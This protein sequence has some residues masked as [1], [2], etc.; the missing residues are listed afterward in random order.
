[1]ASKTN[2]NNKKTSVKQSPLKKII[3]PI[4]S[5]NFKPD[6]IEFSNVIVNTELGNKWINT[7]INNDKI[8]LVARGCVVK[9][10]KKLDNND[11]DSKPN[12]KKDSSYAKKDK[13]QAFLG[14]TDADFIKA[15]KTYD[16][17]LISFGVKRSQELFDTEMNADECGE[18]FKSTLSFHDKY[19][20]AI[21]GILS[22][23]FSCESKTEDVPDVS[24]LIAALDKNTV[25]DV[26]FW[27]N[28]IKLG[29]G[30]YSVGLE[31]LKINITGLGSASQYKSN[32]ITVDEFQ[33]G[34]ITLT[35][36]EVLDKGSKKCKVLYGE[37]ESAKPLRLKFENIKARM[38]LNKQP[39]EEKESYSLSIR[40]SDPA[41]RKVIVN[42]DE[43]I[44]KILLEKSKEY[45]DAKK[46]SKLLRPI[47][48]SLLSYNKADQEKIKK[49]EKPQ[50]E[51]SLWIKIY[52]SEEKKFDG[53]ITNIE[54]K[55]A[56]NN[57]EDLIGKDLDI[58][59][60][61][62]YSKHI[63][64]GP[65]GTSINFTLNS[66][67][68]SFDVPEYDLDNVD[69]ASVSDEEEEISDTPVDEVVDSDEE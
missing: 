67:E 24:D 7:T 22:R 18:M 65:K 20:Y 60:L 36:R 16:D 30:K 26:C 69:N 9:T 63:W 50:Y 28:K 19:G 38:F 59:N 54:G 41:I 46:T 27:F 12:A 3:K 66:C 2:D 4:D 35:E 1:M 48:K 43:E 29:V 56:I 21:G 5:K 32:A 62:I 17:S 33:T 57:T 58:A 44:F 40:L 14:V 61:E 51:P 64:F 49:G 6:I 39:G 10:F 45:Y 23:E 53:K 34:K 11:K 47:V 8:L 31:I 25:I 13:Y 68:I 37:G 42:I 55:K 52:H 15:V